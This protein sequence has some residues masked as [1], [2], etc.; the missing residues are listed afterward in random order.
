MKM[1]VIHTHPTKSLLGDLC[2]ALESFGLSTELR[3]S[4]IYNY[5]DYGISENDLKSLRI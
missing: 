5:K 1:F 4:H 3:V 2:K